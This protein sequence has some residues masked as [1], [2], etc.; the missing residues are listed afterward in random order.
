VQSRDRSSVSAA[1][2]P[3]RS[4]LSMDG[5]GPLRRADGTE[6][7][8]VALSPTTSRD[9]LVLVLAPTGRDEPLT[10]GL[11]SD[12]GGVTCEPATDVADL[13][14]KI[15][16][17]AGAAVIAEEGL[18]FGGANR[19]LDALAA[20]LPWS[21]LPVLILSD[22]A[23]EDTGGSGGGSA[24]S[25]LRQRG[26]VTV[27]D[28]PVRIVT[29]LSAV[30]A[31]LR[32]RRRQYEVRD[33]LI[34]AREAIRHRDQFLAMLGH[35]L[36]N[37][38]GAIT[39]AMTVLDVTKPDA[40]EIEVEH[41]EII[42]RQTDHLARLVDDLLDVSR[43]TSGK[44]VLQKKPVDLCELVRRAA[45]AMEGP[46]HARRHELVARCDGSTPFV[47]GDPLRLEQV[48][49]NLLT[50]AIKYTPS[51]GKIEV[52]VETPAAAND[53][54]SVLV[55]VRDNGMGI[56]PELMGRVFDLFIQAEPTLDRSQGG[57]GIGLT[58]VK[59]LI[60]MHDGE[61][62]V[63]SEGHGRGSEFVI[64]L[65]RIARPAQVQTPST[66]PA[67]LGHKG[68]RRRILVIEDQADA[69]RA[70][71]RLLQLWGHEVEAAED[72][73]IGLERALQ[74][75]P[76]IAL[77]D[78]GLPGIDGYELARRLRAAE[79]NLKGIRLIALT[80]YGQPEDRERA[81]EAGFD[82]HIVKPVDREQLTQAINDPVP[83]RVHRAAAAA[84]SAQIAADVQGGV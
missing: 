37:P 4:P 61:V 72:G 27:L 74:F 43:I 14:D 57:L 38:L 59:A 67:H 36:R 71:Q 12:R 33:L 82:L 53:A 70:L 20:Q 79:A 7:A 47:N 78:V 75:K 34:A 54:K 51:G 66:L 3:G 28:R 23:R 30:H 44:V 62:T 9:E 46:A 15:A 11:L 25:V 73:V 49:N 58:L 16:R 64:R 77:I 42:R 39:N 50:N 8:D 19:L 52:N 31:A 81:Y 40:G 22:S 76:E 35:E 60:E 48:V 63:K 13:C 6:G 1:I 84:I 18:D 65:P 21:D 56:P 10:C 69:R 29:L 17:G 32:A 5:R 80:G 68:K 2:N 41:R 45:K 83:P 24:V 55:R 26:N